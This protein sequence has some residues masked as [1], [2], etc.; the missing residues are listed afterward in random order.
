MDT[1]FDR[2]QEQGIDLS[3][4]SHSQSLVLWYHILEHMAESNEEKAYALFMCSEYEVKADLTEK[5][6]ATYNEH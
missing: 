4:L 5:V 2:I 6:S 1:F 3:V